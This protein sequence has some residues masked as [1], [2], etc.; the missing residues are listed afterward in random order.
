MSEVQS[1]ILPNLLEKLGQ[2]LKMLMALFELSLI[3][4]DHLKLNNKTINWAQNIKPILE[5]HSTLYEQKKFEIEDRLTSRTLALNKD[6]ENM[7]PK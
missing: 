2:S 3:S 7:F 1:T 4:K 6:I 5:K